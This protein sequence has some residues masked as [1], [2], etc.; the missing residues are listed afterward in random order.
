MA[1][2]PYLISKNDFQGFPFKTGWKQRS[3]FCYLWFKRR[4]QFPIL[5]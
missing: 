5:F 1:I 4:S 2:A 3:R